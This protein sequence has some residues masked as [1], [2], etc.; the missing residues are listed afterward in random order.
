MGGR[1]GELTW[2]SGLW[3]LLFTPLYFNYKINVLSSSGETGR[4]VA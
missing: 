4:V 2:F 3:T 1:S